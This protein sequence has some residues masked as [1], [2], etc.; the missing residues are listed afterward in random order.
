MIIVQ[1][2]VI[3]KSLN[4]FVFANQSF[5]VLSRNNGTVYNDELSDFHST[6][7]RHDEKGPK[8][9]TKPWEETI[10]YNQWMVYLTTEIL[11]Y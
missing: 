4:V 6:Y 2:C 7:R 10:V 8:L 11:R 1:M 5:M 9:R 3:E